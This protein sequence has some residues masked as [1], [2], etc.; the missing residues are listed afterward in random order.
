MTSNCSGVKLQPFY[1]A[2]DFVNQESGAGFAHLGRLSGF[3]EGSN[4]L[5]TKMAPLCAWQ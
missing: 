1:C 2:H 5:D 4:G 3:S